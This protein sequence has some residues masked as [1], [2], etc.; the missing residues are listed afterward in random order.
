MRIHRIEMEGFGPFRTLQ[1]VDLDRFAS[2]GL[3]LISGRTGTGKSSIL[4]AVC[5][6]LYGSTPRYDGAEQ[7]FR[8][9]HAEPGEP[10]QVAVEFSVDD[11]RWRVERTPEYARPKRRGEGMT[12]EAPTVEVS[13]RVDGEWIGRASRAVDAGQLIGEVVGLNQQQFLQVILLAQGRFARFLLAKND[14]RQKLLRTLFGT[15]RFQDYEQAFDERRRAQAAEVAARTEALRAILDQAQGDVLRAA[16]PG[17]EQPDLG[18]DDEQSAERLE[19]RLGRLDDAAARS[20]QAATAAD[21]AEAVARERRAAAEA[22]R[23]RVRALRDGQRRRDAAR[24]QLAELDEIREELGERRREL[25][26]ARRAAVVAPAADAASR[27]EAASRA[28]DDEETRARDAWSEARSELGFTAADSGDTST[29]P[30]DT[31][32]GPAGEDEG[33]SHAGVGDAAERIEVAAAADEPTQGAHESTDGTRDGAAV[34]EHADESGPMPPADDAAPEALDAFVA[35]S[36]ASIGAW[37]PA[38]EIET[39]LDDETQRLDRQRDELEQTE[40]QLAELAERRAA[41]PDRI[42]ENQREIDAAAARAARR[43]A[44]EAQIA[45]LEAQ[46]SAV[47]EV[48]RLAEAYTAAHAASLA[49]TQARRAAEDALAEL[50]ARRLAGYAGELAASLA[51]G[52][53]CAVCGSTSHPSPAPLADDHV[54]PEAIDAAEEA[55]TRAVAADERAA[56]ARQDAQVELRAA[57]ERAGGREEVEI[58]GDLLA[59][60]TQLADAEQAASEQRDLVDVRTA[61]AAERDELAETA[62]RLE[63]ERGSGRATIAAAERELAEH[64]EA[65]RAARGGFPSVAA[66]IGALQRLASRASALADAAREA[67]RARTAASEAASSLERALAEGAFGSAAE[68]RAARRTPDEIAALERRLADADAARAAAQAALDEVATLEL[69]EEAVDAAPSE[70]ALAD[71]QQ[72]YDRAVDARGEARRRAEALAD[73]A[74][75][76][77][78]AHDEVAGAAR[79]AEAVARLADALAGRAHNTRRMNLET[80]VLAAELEEIVE[81]ANVR[82]A[83]MSNERYALQH[84]DALAR[85]GA[86][87]GLGIEIMDRYTGQARPPHSLS[88]GETFLASLAL[89]LGLAEVVTRRAGGIRL[90]T[91]FIDEGFGS[92][93][94]E[95]LDIAMRTLDA[96]RQ[97]GRTIGVISHV[98]AMQEQIPAQLRV[99]QTKE[100]WSVVDP[101][102][103]ATLEA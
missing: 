43:E 60:R 51:P 32:V 59:V 64:R 57:E 8:S 24:A 38:R 97:G 68:A 78:S 45:Q 77:R 41:L 82:L 28:A 75:R 12:T 52:E 62:A 92:L 85:R 79:E 20:A 72:A 61:L 55:R 27:A 25:D 30:G 53:A 29:E 98:A 83:E 95:T 6:A 2:D 84:T 50:H 36:G 23:D 90:D 71:A 99:R 101:P 44:F 4:D 66:R 9:D 86:A 63:S 26:A 94:G 58:N 7:R 22:E 39:L 33:A 49:A 16:E 47:R 74:T 87:S 1:T 46:V 70:Q 48:G 42:D 56:A 67:G 14:E 89:A 19:D 88:G 37:R 54:T 80:F 5:F 17:T 18:A 69:P 34:E 10:T 93:D 65:V 96:L 73:A 81:A 91:L 11:T 100:G 15:R 76:A 102:R 31:G 3:F 103:E 35:L 13:E 40:R 21:A